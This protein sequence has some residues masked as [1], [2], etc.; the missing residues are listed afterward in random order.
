MKR[1]VLCGVALLIVGIIGYEDL[2]KPPFPAHVYTET[3]T[4]LV[5]DGHQVIV[6]GTVHCERGSSYDP[7]GDFWPWPYMLFPPGGRPM[8]YECTPEWLATRLPDGSALLIG[9]F[10]IGGR[11]DGYFD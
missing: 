11:W 3:R 4:E 6:D 5:W 7:A 9:A 2:R 10:G 8:L 1:V